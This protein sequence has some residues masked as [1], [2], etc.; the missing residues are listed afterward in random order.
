MKQVITTTKDTEETEV[1]TLV[2]VNVFFG[3]CSFCDMDL[4]GLGFAL[5][6]AGGVA[7][8]GAGWEAGGFSRSWEALWRGFGPG[9]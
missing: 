7:G 3:F 4:V 8:R 9:A 5:H 2:F 6:E 1:G